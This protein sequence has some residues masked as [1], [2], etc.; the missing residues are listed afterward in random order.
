MFVTYSLGGKEHRTG[1]AQASSSPRWMYEKCVRLD[2]SSVES[3]K[4]HTLIDV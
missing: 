4:V 3:A 1:T 2:T